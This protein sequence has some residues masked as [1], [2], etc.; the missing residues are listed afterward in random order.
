MT[1][2]QRITAAIMV[3]CKYAGIDGAHHKQWVIDQMLRKLMGPEE[4]AEFVR[5]RT[6]GPLGEPGHY[7]PWDE[8]IAP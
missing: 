5:D 6:L 8:G 2:E 1:P 4:Y 7:E 3:A